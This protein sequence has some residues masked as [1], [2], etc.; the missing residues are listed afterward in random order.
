MNPT[1]SNDEVTL[2]LSNKYFLFLSL[3]FF[4]NI[5]NS[6][7]MFYLFSFVLVLF[8]FFLIGMYPRN[9]LPQESRKGNASDKGKAKATSIRGK[10]SVSKD[11]LKV[12]DV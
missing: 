12:P 2:H 10:E 11:S 7:N 8:G 6:K 1:A 5:Q 4:L 3:T 9:N